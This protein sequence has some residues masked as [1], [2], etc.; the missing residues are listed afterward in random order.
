MADNVTLVVATDDVSGNHYQKVKLASGE[1]DATTGVYTGN[2]SATNSLRVTVADDST[3]VLSVAGGVAHDSADSGNP[4]KVGARAKSALS[5]VTLVASDDRTNLHADLD[6]ALLV[7]P[8]STIADKVSGNAS[9]TDGTST[10]CIAAQ[11]A[12]IITELTLVILTNMH[13]TDTIYVE[14]KD[15]TTTKLTVPV[16]AK[17]G[18]VVPIPDGLPGTANTAWNFDPSAATTTIYCSMVGRKIKG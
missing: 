17:G 13:A 11:G 15:G 5:A 12:G 6:G 4:L 1:A 9:N 16:P 14:I 18:V 2:G 7:R 3:G 10:Q 8:G